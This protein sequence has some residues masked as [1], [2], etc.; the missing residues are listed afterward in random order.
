MGTIEYLSAISGIVVAAAASS[1]SLRRKFQEIRQRKQLERY[2]KGE[3][4]ELDNGQRTSA[5]LEAKLKMTEAQVRRAA[6]GSDYVRLVRKTDREGFTKC[7][8][9]EYKSK[10]N[11]REG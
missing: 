1:K 11:S 5:H 2:L 3:K 9:F 4:G 6:F 10:K 8:L 7:I